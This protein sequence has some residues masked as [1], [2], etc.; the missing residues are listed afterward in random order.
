MGKDRKLLHVFDSAK[1]G[2]PD[3][4]QGPASPHTIDPAEQTRIWRDSERVKGPPPK[5]AKF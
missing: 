2:L 4:W 5:D 1:R 3:H